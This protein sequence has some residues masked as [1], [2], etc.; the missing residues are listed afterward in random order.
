MQCRLAALKSPTTHIYIYIANY[1]NFPQIGGRGPNV[2]P[3]NTRILIIGTL[4]G[5]P[6]MLGRS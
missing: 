6:L 2:E 5:V 3:Q 1:L 4:K